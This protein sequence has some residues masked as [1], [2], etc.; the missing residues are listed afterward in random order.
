LA[1]NVKLRNPIAAGA[2][3][4]WSDVQVDESATAV[5]FRREMERTFAPAR[6]WAA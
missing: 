5:S 2:P 3:I 4:R 6:E 1:H